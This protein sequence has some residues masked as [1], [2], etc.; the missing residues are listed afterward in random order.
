MRVRPFEMNDVDRLNALFDETAWPHISADHW[1]WLMANPAQGQT[2]VAWVL[3]SEGRIDGVLGNFRQT[4]YRSQDRFRAATLHSILV[5]PRVK[6]SL[7][8]LFA[9]ITSQSELFALTILNANQIGAPA[10]VRMGMQLLQT[11]THDVKLSWRLDPSQLA[12]SR[13]LRKLTSHKPALYRRL[14]EWLTP[15]TYG[16]FNARSIKWPDNIALIEDLSDNSTMGVFW[17]ALQDEGQ[18]I[19]D[20]SPA[21]LRWRMAAP[22]V[23]RPPLMLG[24]TDT[25]GI[26]AYAMAQLAKPGPIDA[27]VLEILDIYGLQRANKLAL[28]ALIDGLIIAAKKMG[29]SKVRL[30]LV[31]PR[32]LKSLGSKLTTAH[33]EG[34]WGHAYANFKPSAADYSDWEPTPFDG[35]YGLIIRQPQFRPTRRA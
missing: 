23:I 17:L 3:D 6:G 35:S 29:A 32:T 5:S 20:R 18:L 28:P 4:Y 14:G 30:P 21:L 10:Y 16:R 7:R 13:V 22:D 8:Q 15:H 31:S 2:P 34:G 19:S 24:Y 26:S 27:P 12:L 33:N 9:P 25:Q 1:R 11:P